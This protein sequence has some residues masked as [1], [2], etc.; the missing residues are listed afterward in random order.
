MRPATGGKGW[1]EDGLG[2]AS[3]GTTFL[4]MGAMLRLRGM[5]RS[6]DVALPTLEAR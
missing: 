1:K 2:I 5:P 3:G 6:G 4:R